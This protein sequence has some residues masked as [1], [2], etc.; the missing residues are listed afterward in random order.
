[1]RLETP[2]AFRA[3]QGSD[4]MHFVILSPSPEAGGCG[5]KS[6]APSAENRFLSKAVTFEP[7]VGQ[8]VTLHA[9]PTSRNS[10]ILICAFPVPSSSCFVVF[11]K[12]EVMCN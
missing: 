2:V 11:F 1:M 12:R 4:V 7:G 6:Y 3:L 8:N 10:T 5:H 9:M